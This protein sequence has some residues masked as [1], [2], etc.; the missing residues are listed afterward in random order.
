VST[1]ADLKTEYDRLHEH[2]RE[3][4]EQ[5]NASLRFMADLLGHPPTQEEMLAHNQDLKAAGLISSPSTI[6]RCTGSWPKALKLAGLTQ[7]SRAKR[8]DTQAT[9][10]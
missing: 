10:G 6:Y 1:T 8:D 5:C 9:K 7:E 4:V 2:W 3:T